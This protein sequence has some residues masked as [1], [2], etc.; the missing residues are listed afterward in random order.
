MCD[1]RCE[2]GDPE[3]V[4]RRRSE[5]RARKR[6][7]ERG[8]RKARPRDKPSLSGGHKAKGAAGGTRLEHRVSFCCNVLKEA[9]ACYGIDAKRLKWDLVGAR[10]N[11][12]K[13]GVSTKKKLPAD[14]CSGAR[15]RWERLNGADLHSRAIASTLRR[16]KAPKQQRALRMHPVARPL[17][18]EQRRSR[19]TQC[20]P[21]H[22]ARLLP[23]KAVRAHLWEGRSDGGQM[24]PRADSGVRGY[25]PI[26]YPRCNHPA[27][28]WRSRALCPPALLPYAHNRAD[29]TR[30]LVGQ[31]NCKSNH[32]KQSL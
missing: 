11:G 8:S 16:S 27:G 6:G 9:N 3:P 5:F 28:P 22:Q 13:H 26:N 19:R 29:A 2:R 12:L 23:H 14:R 30:K 4:E 15:G 1:A 18:S 24:K 17:P 10:Y 20:K 7:R 32:E 21:S 31:G 25:W